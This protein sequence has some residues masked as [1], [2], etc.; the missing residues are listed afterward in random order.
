MKRIWIHPE[1][2]QNAKRYWR[3]VSELERRENFLKDPGPRVP[4]W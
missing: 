3:S 1:E 2:P 4:R